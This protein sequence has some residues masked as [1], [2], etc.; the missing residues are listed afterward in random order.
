MW[1]PCTVLPRCSINA[2][3][4]TGSNLAALQGNLLCRYREVKMEIEVTTW[5]RED[6]RNAGSASRWHCTGCGRYGPYDTRRF[7]VEIASVEHLDICEA[8]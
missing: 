3:T 5:E 2:R 4:V 6:W 7:A 1:T 8:S